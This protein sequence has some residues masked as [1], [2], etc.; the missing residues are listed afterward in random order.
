V[1]FFTQLEPDL[2]ELEPA[3]RKHFLITDVQNLTMVGWIYVAVMFVYVPIDFKS[4]G[5]DFAFWSLTMA[6]VVVIVIGLWLINALNNTHSVKH[7]DRL[8][9]LGSLFSCAFSLWVHFVRGNTN[10]Y[11]LS[12]TVILVMMSYI[13]LPMPLSWRFWTA[14]PFSVLESL[15]WL[16]LTK[17]DVLET[18]RNNLFGIIL[19]N[20]T[21]LVVSIRFYTL[22]R[23][24]YKA[25]LEEQQARLK[26]ERLATT[27]ELTEVFNRRK[28][29]EEANRS[30]ARFLRSGQCFSVL[31]LD[32]DHFKLINDTHGHVN[33]D[34]VLKQF[35]QVVKQQVRELDVLGRFG[36]E[37]FVVLLPETQLELAKGIAGRIRA[38]VEALN[39]ELGAVKTQLTVSIGVTEVS[40]E[41]SKI[42]DVLHRADVALYQAKTLGR[43][44]VALESPHK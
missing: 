43:N 38:S 1:K 22:R 35:A 16:L 7:F 23:E 30:L 5:L 33:G 39:L 10:N 2:G 21:G 20:V 15:L 32:V 25:Q 8:L 24:Q 4:Y 11:N 17:T 41:D 40:L 14:I 13:L 27:D 34:L 31:Y 3:Y 44:R 26:I 6:R 37:E 18:F 9:L 36:G 19:A 12:I 42:E 29:L 28:W